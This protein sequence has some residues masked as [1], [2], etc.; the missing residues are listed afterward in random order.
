[1]LASDIF[2]LAWFVSVIGIFVFAVSAIINLF[3]RRSS[4]EDWKKAF[5]FFI[6]SAI[7]LVIFGLTFEREQETLINGDSVESS[8]VI[9]NSERLVSF[10]M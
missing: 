3:R 9:T 5:I 4:K 2:A 1:M 6:L 7:L 10:S 8:E